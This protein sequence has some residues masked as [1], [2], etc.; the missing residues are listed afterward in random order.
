MANGALAHTL[1]Q[2]VG[3]RPK[4]L[5]KWV[6]SGLETSGEQRIITLACCLSGDHLGAGSGGTFLS[7][8]I[9]HGWRYSCPLRTEAAVLSK[10]IDCS[11]FDYLAMRF[12]KHTLIAARQKECQSALGCSAN[13]ESAN[14]ENPNGRRRYSFWHQCERTKPG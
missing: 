11:N 2:S 12:K 14:K 1:G 6:T 7:N 5:S 3:C 4:R 13:S 10:W 8:A 9:V